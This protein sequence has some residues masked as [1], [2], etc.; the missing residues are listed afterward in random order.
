MAGGRPTKYSSAILEETKSYIE[1]YAD[2]DHA[3][4]SVAGLSIKLNIA[5]S[6]LYDWASQ[7]GKEEFS[8]ILEKLNAVQEQT[9]VSKGL[10][11]EFNPAI[12][13]LALGK[14]GYSEKTDNT[15]THQ[16]PNGEPLT[17][18]E[19]VTVSARKKADV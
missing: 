10:K 11:G 16:G 4:P 9:L 8:D 7:E 12:T 2:E 13:K 15:N 19:I 17:A 18:V 14:H 6:T 1:N 5:R 3:I